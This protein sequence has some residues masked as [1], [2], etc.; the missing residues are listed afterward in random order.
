MW[1]SRKRRE[2]RERAE[3]KITELVDGDRK[4]PKTAKT[5]RK[6]K[7][8]HCHGHAVMSNGKPCRNCDAGWIYL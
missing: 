8:G 7:C 5:V 4:H 1:E 3:A 6:Q 2:A